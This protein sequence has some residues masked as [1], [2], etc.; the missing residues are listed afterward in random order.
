MIS[1]SLSYLEFR[2]APGF[3][4]GLAFLYGILG[5]AALAPFYLI[6]LLS[7]A[8]CGILHLTHLSRPRASFWLGW[9]FG[10]GYF[11]G[12]L[13]WIAF[14]LGVDLQRFAWMI[15]FAVLGLPAV[16]SFFVAPVFSLVSAVPFSLEKRLLFFASLWALFE[17]LRG[18]LLTGFPW[19]LIGYCWIGW[20]PMAQ[21]LSL[22][23]IYGLSFL[24]ALWASSPLLWREKKRGFGGMILLGIGFALFGF[25]RLHQG[26]VSSVPG[27]R[28]RLVQPSIPQHLK[29]S[30]QHREEN[31]RI[32]LELTRLPSRGSPP[33]FYIWP[34]S[35]TPFFLAN[36]T[37]RRL[38]L[39]KALSLP[40]DA[41]LVTGTARGERTAEGQVQ[42]WNSFMGVNKEGKI[43]SLYDKSHLVPFGEYVPF[44][45][46]LGA[47]IQ[48][49]T[50]GAIDYS[51]GRGPQTLILPGAPPFSPLICYEVIFPGA[52]KSREGIS[53]QWLLNITNDAW[54]GLTSGPFQHLAIA[55]ARAIEEGLP[56]V[57]VGNNGISAIIDAYGRVLQHLNL[58]AR[59]VI[60]SSLPKCLSSH[61]PYFYYGDK[62]FGL[63]LLLSFA[64]LFWSRPKK[65][66]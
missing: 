46:F 50:P 59:S 4:R 66:S 23:G 43:L 49:V 18:H 30:E 32:L 55:R 20:L 35:A 36:H 38:S 22:F 53:P 40:G 56:V 60:D 5:A 41:I 26:E 16:L 57:R 7:I 47:I 65:P 19:N 37:E 3:Q 25:W 54:Y 31:I 24:T 52:V 15:P 27:V 51:A 58:D 28:L 12:G 29:W 44:R 2:A 11:C 8:F 21:S 39:L 9:W 6:P 61:T 45:T 1:L 10:L 13:Y 14:A 63:F 62:I 33:N 42:V 48:K 34:E 64:F 17:W